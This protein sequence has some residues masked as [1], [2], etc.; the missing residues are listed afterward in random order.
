M[1]ALRVDRGAQEVHV[2]H[3]WD[4]DRVLEGEEQPLARPLI[5]R[6]GKEIA[7]EITHSAFAD[8][9]PVAAGEHGGQRALAGPVRPHDRV[10]LPA[11]HR[12]VDASQYLATIRE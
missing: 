9:V 10:H 5:G 2:V 3:A 8:L 7:A 6:H 12:E 11:M 1:A 4:L